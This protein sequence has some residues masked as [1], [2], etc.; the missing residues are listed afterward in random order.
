[1]KFDLKRLYDLLPT[2]YQ[3][4]DAEL[5]LKI[6]QEI[7]N[8]EMPEY[9]DEIYGPLK[10]IISIIAD[11][12]GILE[13]NIDQLYDDLFIETCAEWVVPYI[14][15]LVGYRSLIEIPDNNFSQRSEVANTIKYRRRKGT[16]SVIEQLARDITGIDANVVEYFQLLAQTQYMNHLRPQNL[17][18]SRITKNPRS[19]SK[20]QEWQLLELANTPFDSMPKSV[21]VRNIVSNRGKYNI[22]NIG[23]YLWR[24]QAY[25][26]TRAP[27]K[28]IDVNRYSFNVLGKDT[29]LYNRPL[30]EKTITQLAKRMNVAM[31]IS[32]RELH[33]DLEMFYGKD[34]SIFLEIDGN[35][36]VPEKAH[37]FSFISSPPS[38]VKL[39]DLICVCNLSDDPNVSG[40]WINMPSD[41]IAIDPVLGRIAVPSDL[42][43]P[44]DERELYVTY[45][46]GFSADIGGGEYERAET[47]DLDTADNVILEVSIGV[48]S[49]QNALDQLANIGGIIE[50]KDNEIYEENLQINIATDKQIEIRA[51]NGY[52]PLI[53]SNS[54]ININGG[55]RSG[56]IF[57]GLMIEGGI[58]FTGQISMLKISHC[59]L[60][61]N[62]NSG[63]NINL[64]VNSIN[65]EVEIEKSITGSLRVVEEAS[66]KINNS[67]ADATNPTETVYSAPI[68]EEFGGKLSIT[69]STIIGR[70]YTKL[71]EMA[72]NTIFIAKNPSLP[73]DFLIMTQR[74]QE[75]CVRFSYF[76][77]KSRL[78]HPFRCQP[79][80]SG[81]EKRVFPLFTSLTYGKAGYCQLS[82]YCVTE[83]SEGADDNAEMGVFHQQYYA[84][85]ASNFRARLDEY[86]RFGMEAGIF[87]AS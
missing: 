67:I 51:S 36:V 76:P 73:K 24:T 33:E 46:Y 71:M 78:P 41:R 68:G 43:S 87:Y 55:E 19:N 2:I 81:F 22:P 11:E 65:T 31:P 44:L 27:A 64:L 12:A 54:F 21:D 38:N 59:T 9:S 62:S 50:I 75:G 77:K 30:A 57:N 7:A 49:I 82:Q 69:N 63:S 60:V 56:V 45:H 23:I 70:V 84:L 20:N 13:K 53:K 15:E 32:R 10:A 25:S 35:D 16:A 42:Q 26:I 83:I 8:G 48:S 37:L 34:E 61:P 5:G 28:K 52:R 40:Q 4:R 66:V 74:I 1:M 14:G 6:Q 85:K 58:N 18:V 17:A 86:L 80:T 3:I 47:F 29:Q 79:S 39:K 72:S